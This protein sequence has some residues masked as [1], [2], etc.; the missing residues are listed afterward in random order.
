M[1]SIKTIEITNNLLN[2]IQRINNH[3]SL[4]TLNK[5]SHERRIYQQIM[6]G[7]TQIRQQTIDA[8][9]QLSNKI[10]K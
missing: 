10:E 9:R 8:C 2:F 3:R 1:L 4:K 7:N 5:E 6:E